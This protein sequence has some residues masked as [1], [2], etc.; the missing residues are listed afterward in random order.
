MIITIVCDVLGKENN[1]TTVAALN[2]IRYLSDRGHD[3]RVLCADIDS[4]DQ[5][6][7]YIVRELKLLPPLSSYVSKVGVDIAAPDLK[8]MK[9]AMDQAD[10]VHI[11]TPFL[12]GT[13]ALYLA[14]HLQIL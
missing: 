7:Y 10:V 6:G 4:R 13:A 12:L 3:V 2:L 8:V 9:Q 5:P 11:M 1:G 14:R